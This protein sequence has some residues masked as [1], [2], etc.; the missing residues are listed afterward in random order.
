MAG[1]RVDLSEKR[2]GLSHLRHSSFPLDPTDPRPTTSEPISDV[3]GASVV[4]YLRKGK[5]HGASTVRE[6]TEKN[7]RETAL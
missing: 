4:M 3:G 1:Y 5:K 7:M 6:R 2:R